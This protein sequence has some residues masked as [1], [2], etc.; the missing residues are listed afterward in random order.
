MSAFARMTHEATRW[1]THTLLATPRSRGQHEH[2]HSNIKRARHSEVN[3]LSNFPKGEN[4]STLQQ[5]KIQI[6]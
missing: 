2:P 1:G 3:F 5:M 4:Q 6:E